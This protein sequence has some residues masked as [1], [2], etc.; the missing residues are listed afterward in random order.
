MVK[1]STISL[2]EFMNL[3]SS[4]KTLLAWVEP[5]QRLIKWTLHSGAI[6]KKTLS[7]FVKDFQVDGV[8]LTESTT[9]A[10]LSAGKFY[11]D[12]QEKTLYV[13]L[14]DSSNPKDHYSMVIYRLFFSSSP[15]YLPYNLITGSRIVPYE[16][17][18]SESSEFGA[19]L[20]SERK[21]TA[22]ESTSTIS[23]YNND[24]YFDDIFDKLIWENK[25]VYVYATHRK[26]ALTDK[27]QL[28]H[29]YITGKTFS[30][31]NISFQI[32]DF[33]KKLSNEVF[34][35]R[36]KAADF[37]YTINPLVSY[38]NWKDAGYWGVK[39]VNS[40]IFSSADY[41]TNDA[42]NYKRR[43]YGKVD[44]MILP[45]ADKIEDTGI[46]LSGTFQSVYG[47][48]DA[49]PY[50]TNYYDGTSSS[51]HTELTPGDVIYKFLPRTNDQGWAQESTTGMSVLT[52][53][54]IDMLT[55]SQMTI[56]LLWVATPPA[57][58]LLS[59]SSSDI[60]TQFVTIGDHICLRGDNILPANRGIWE[61]T[62]KSANTLY[63]SDSLKTGTTQLSAEIN[64]SD[65]NQNNLFCCKA[66]GE[67]I[68]VSATSCE[69]TGAASAIFYAIPNTSTTLKNRRFFI[70]HHKLHEINTTIASVS[71]GKQY[72]TVTSRI[73]EFKTGDIILLKGTP[74]LIDSKADDTN[75]LTLTLYPATNEQGII[76]F[77]E[78]IAPGDP[79][80]RP[81][82][83]RLYHTTDR[84][85]TYSIFEYNQVYGK[86]LSPTDYT[87]TN[88]TTG[89]YITLNSNIE[90]NIA[91]AF[92]INATWMT[93]S[94]IVYGMFNANMKNN[95]WI[96]NKLENKWY[97]IEEI[98]DTGA[99]ILREAFTGTSGIDLSSWKGVEYIGDDSVIS[100]DLYGAIDENNL[101]IDTCPK[102][103]RN[104]LREIGLDSQLDDIDIEADPNV[105]PP[106]V[107]YISSFTNASKAAPLLVSL[108][109]PLS[110]SDTLPSYKELINYMN[111]T[112][113]GCLINNITYQIAYSVFEPKRSLGNVLYL[114]DS[115]ILDF[116][117]QV[118][119]SKIVSKVTAD[120]RF[121]DYNYI[122][123][124]QNPTNPFEISNSDVAYSSPDFVNIMNIK[125]YLYNKKD[126]EQIAGRYGFIN[127]TSQSL[128][129]IQ[130]KLQTLN[131]V[132]ND[133]VEIDF[134][135]LYARFGSSG[136]EGL[137]IGVVNDIKKTEK[138]VQLTI[139]DLGN[140]FNACGTITPAGTSSFGSATT[141]E[142]RYYAY[143]TD[144]DG[145]ILD[146]ESTLD[147]NRVF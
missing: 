124:K 50:R 8:S 21:G 25:E 65:K 141:R 85:R 20:D 80:Y 117:V 9:L 22:I 46:C 138:G 6:Y 49:V 19:S 45:A 135:R 30:A 129:I 63:L 37:T 120:Y 145:I 57:H 7:F 33:Y 16:P 142:K 40:E 78:T 118:D 75:R 74:C 14:T 87:I 111:E 71:P 126:A 48:R 137:K 123:A 106:I 31:E 24:R 67:R 68:T 61:V 36:Y 131:L 146:D 116:T 102:V 64:T 110:T 13:W 55:D 54:K 92:S 70:S 143:M 58:F 79:V 119:S 132:I 1:A 101:L 47:V 127:R 104:V 81:A 29:G 44:G 147:T 38:S 94:K 113:Y 130:T 84:K 108:T 59:G 26:L 12:P 107:E 11:Y 27:V 34:N 109:L 76:D 73:G 139:D 3:S 128:V 35:P 112:I 134:D 53:S 56:E 51:I 105:D 60:D 52:L 90:F 144:N 2:S 4:E 96:L 39:E 93:G 32:T 140:T 82:I 43:I 72:I 100:C 97:K 66:S 77:L 5:G 86:E 62:N 121:R 41:T 99:V 15:I 42:G 122:T 83:Q 28:I 98:I 115:D 103:V 89:A 88:E 114:D 133:L 18:I 136:N 91:E 17:L 10:G 125:L 69:A 23:F 95:D